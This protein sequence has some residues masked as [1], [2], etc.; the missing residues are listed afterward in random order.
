MFYLRATI[1]IA[2]RRCAP[3]YPAA[4]I[5]SATLK[6]INDTGDPGIGF[7]GGMWPNDTGY[8][9]TEWTSSVCVYYYYLHVG[10]FVLSGGDMLLYI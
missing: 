5:I 7:H 8:A 10:Y 4:K 1:F 2:T 9:N 3:T 6:H